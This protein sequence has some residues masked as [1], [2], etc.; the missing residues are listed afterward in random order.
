MNDLAI[1]GFTVASAAAACG[2]LLLGARYVCRR[3][4]G[5][6]DDP[7]AYG[8][9]RV[10]GH[11]DSGGS[12]EVY[13]ARHRCAPQL[14]ALKVLRC[15]DGPDDPAARRRFE[16]EIELTSSLDHPNTI[17]VLEYGRADRRRYY[18]AMEY[19]EGMNL[20]QL[21]DRFGPLP[22]ARCAHIL[23]QVCGSLAEAHGKGI[24]HRDVKPGNIFLTEGEG[25]ADFVKVLDFGLGKRVGQPSAELTL[26]GVV[27]GTPL[28]MAPECVLGS[29]C[30]DERAD[31]YSLGGVAYFMLTGLPPFT[32]SSAIGVLAEHIKTRPRAPSAIAGRPIRPELEELVLRCLEKDPDDRIQSA[33][34]L[35]AALR[36]IEFDRA[37]TND[38]ARAWWAARRC[39]GASRAA[40]GEPVIQAA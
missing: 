22:S 29:G 35:A 16:R 12:G 18:Y 39:E 28:Y 2:L 6:G 10:V 9:Y 3:W 30:L 25:T 31:L 20:Q 33:S 14:S 7:D 34:E 26:P 5:C 17:R 32:S 27:F 21:V 4:G 37:W 8:D 40:Q 15:P 23:A 38:D 19:L 24:V 11:L 13:L 36:A 1:F